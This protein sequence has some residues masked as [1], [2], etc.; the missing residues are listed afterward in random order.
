MGSTGGFPSRA[1][2]PCSR[3][4]FARWM[5]VNQS[6]STSVGG[7]RTGSSGFGFVIIG[8]SNSWAPASR[9]FRQDRLRIAYA[10]TTSRGRECLDCVHPRL[11]EPATFAPRVGV[12]IGAVSKAGVRAPEAIPKKTRRLDR[13]WLVATGAI[14]TATGATARPNPREYHNPHQSPFPPSDV[15]DLR[16]RPRGLQDPTDSRKTP[17]LPDA[18]G[19]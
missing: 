14:R 15:N 17:S 7:L 19:G 12:W 18:T 1:F 16:A 9:T 6:S 4:A 5:R 2:W 11:A 3:A 8:S 10:Q 13:F